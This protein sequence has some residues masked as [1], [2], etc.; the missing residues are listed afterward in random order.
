MVEYSRGSARPSAPLYRLLEIAA[1]LVLFSVIASQCSF[2][3]N[4]AS[5]NHGN[6]AVLNIR[7]NIV[8]AVMA[9][10]PPP[11]P[12]RPLIP[13]VSFNVSTI[14]PNVEVYKETRPYSAPVSSGV[15]PEGAVLE[16]TTVVTR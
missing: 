5:G 9:V 3:Q 8:P 2:A 15:G 14:Q 10:P 12:Y 7:V 4:G 11:E 13:G 1:V 16:T 6:Q